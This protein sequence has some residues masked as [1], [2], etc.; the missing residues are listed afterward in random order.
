MTKMCSF[1]KPS[2]KLYLVR[3]FVASR[4]NSGDEL[5]STMNCLALN[6]EY[7]GVPNATC[8]CAKARAVPVG[9]STYSPASL[10]KTSSD[11]LNLKNRNGKRRYEASEVE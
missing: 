2:I 9:A 10:T 5:L 3:Y 6:V 4:S 7:R 1:V 8:F 11:S